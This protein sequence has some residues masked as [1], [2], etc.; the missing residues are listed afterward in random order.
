MNLDYCYDYY[1]IKKKSVLNP[2]QNQ[3]KIFGK[4]EPRNR[5]GLTGSEPSIKKPPNLVKTEKITSQTQMWLGTN[6]PWPKQPQ[7]KWTEPETG[8]F[9]SL[10]ITVSVLARQ[11]IRIS[12]LSINRFI[13]NLLYF[14][15]E[16]H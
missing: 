10:K 11:R 1:F 3:A 12:V 4:T 6:R 9:F 2:V 13:N 15:N 5:F 7:I 14:Q 16:K 8:N